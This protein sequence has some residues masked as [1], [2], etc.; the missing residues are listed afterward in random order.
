MY[1]IDG[2]FI[3]KVAPKLSGA[4]AEAQAAIIG[5]I[6]PVFTTVL[7]GYA[8]NTKLRIAHFM[9]QVTHECASGA[10]AGSS[11]CLWRT[12]R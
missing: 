9:G 4:R 3:L 1:P 11:A 6:A 8:I 10:S 12:S 7:D 2:D 5:A